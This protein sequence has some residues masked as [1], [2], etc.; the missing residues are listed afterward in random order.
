MVHENITQCVKKEDFFNCLP[1][2]NTTGSPMRYLQVQ[3][4][5]MVLTTPLFEIS[6]HQVV[7]SL[8]M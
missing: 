2:Y 1:P 7:Q 6:Y 5:R 4:H 3:V 8:Q